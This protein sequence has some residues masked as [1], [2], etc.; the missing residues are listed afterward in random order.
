MGGVAAR[1]IVLAVVIGAL[2]SGC[3]SGPSQVGSAA[4]IGPT[5]VPT[6]DIEARLDQAL[7]RTEIVD[8]LSAQGITTPDI[9]RDIVTQSVLHELSVVAARENGIVVTDADVDAELASLGGPDAVLERFLG[10]LPTVRERV[11]DQL[12]A[13]RLAT[14][15]VSTLAVTVDIVGVASRSDAEAAAKILAAGGPA[16]DAYFAANPETS[17][18]GYEYRASTN[19][20]V[21]ISPVFGTP[22]GG[23][24][25]FQPVPGQ[26][27]WIAFRVVDRRTDAPPVPP[28]MDALAQVGKSGL[29]EI[30]TRQLQPVADA[31]GVRVNPRYG[32]WDQVSL[33]VLDEDQVAGGILPPSSSRP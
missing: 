28:D 15:Q 21:A 12:V 22:V 25:W 3:G 5:A 11:W 4:I 1:V 33:R 23:A 14:Q 27:S 19:P 20:E 8:Q 32:V 2:V 13:E 24:G 30:G 18:R 10:D 31:V 6:Q 26:D 9:V 17:R 7:S 16:A 29:V